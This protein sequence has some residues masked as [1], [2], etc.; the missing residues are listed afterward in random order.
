MMVLTEPH[1]APRG[2]LGPG[3]EAVLYGFLRSA[4]LYS[5]IRSTPGGRVPAIGRQ[6]LSLAIAQRVFFAFP[7]HIH[8]DF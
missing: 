4:R 3:R 2:R 6:Y 8:P 7:Y 5:P 1:A